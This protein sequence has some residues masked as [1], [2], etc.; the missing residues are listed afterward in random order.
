MI[1][2]KKT[3]A[4]TF[5]GLIEKTQN[6]AR[7][8]LQQ[9]IFNEVFDDIPKNLLLP[10]TFFNYQFS[11]Q[12]YTVSETL[13]SYNDGSSFMSRYVYGSGEMYV[14]AVPL[15]VEFTDLPNH[16]IFVPMMYNIALFSNRSGKLAYFLGHDE[17]IEV[18][19][20]KVDAESV[21]KMTGVN[22]ELIPVQKSVGSSVFIDVKDQVTQSGEYILSLEETGFSMPVSFNYDRTESL[23]NCLSLK[24][25]KNRYA[26]SGINVLESMEESITT[27]VKQLDEGIVLW[28]LCVI[29]ALV[30][31]AVEILLLRFLP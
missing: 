9:A 2:C 23:L 15:D 20:E 4:N 19:N 30:F 27:A 13:L 22:G 6:L 12:I 14:C 24:Q 25:L 11:K 18:P 5:S 31:L 26:E 28:K 8:N 3:N 1:S 10:K 16:A 17:L 21:Y 29:L 7:V